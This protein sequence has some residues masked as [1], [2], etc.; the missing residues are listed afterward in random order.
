MPVS[1]DKSTFLSL[2]GNLNGKIQYYYVVLQHSDRETDY[3]PLLLTVR[4]YCRKIQR[5]KQETDKLTE[6]DKLQW[7]CIPDEHKW[8]KIFSRCQIT[9]ENL[10]MVVAAAHAVRGKGTE[11]EMGWGE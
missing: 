1:L 4:L 9:P 7:V 11:C 6:K 10:K 3:L 5:D 8:L 2:Q